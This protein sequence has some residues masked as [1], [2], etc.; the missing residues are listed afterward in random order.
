[1][2]HTFDSEVSLQYWMLWPTV[3][4]GAPLQWPR[5]RGAVCLPSIPTKRDSLDYRV[6]PFSYMAYIIFESS[7]KNMRSYLGG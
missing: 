7:I 2:T 5:W 3:R 1:M 6:I 4:H